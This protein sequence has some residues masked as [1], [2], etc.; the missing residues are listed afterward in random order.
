MS[1]IISGDQL[2]VHSYRIPVVFDS[3]NEPGTRYLIDESGWT[4]IPNHLGYKHINWFRKESKYSKNEAF[5]NNYEAEVEGSKGKT[6]TV[7]CI[8]DV[9][10]CTCPAYGW[11]GNSHTCKHIEKVKKDNKWS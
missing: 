6:Y 9:W 5:K 7:K 8:D 4:A 11:S 10:S 1:V 2:I 3:I